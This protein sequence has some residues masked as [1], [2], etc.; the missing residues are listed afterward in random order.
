MVGVMRMSQDKLVKLFVEKNRIEWTEAFLT[1][2]AIADLQYEYAVKP[3]SPAVFLID[4]K[5]VI[6]AWGLR[7]EEIKEAIS[8]SLENMGK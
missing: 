4:A 2:S 6:V 1:G 3:G 7:G 8:L 5:G